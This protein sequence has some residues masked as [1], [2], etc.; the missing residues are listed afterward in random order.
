MSDVIREAMKEQRK[1]EARRKLMKLRTLLSTGAGETFGISTVKILAPIGNGPYTMW[2]RGCLPYPVGT[3][4]NF[5]LRVWEK[6]KQVTVTDDRGQCPFPELLS[7]IWDLISPSWH[8]MKVAARG[9]GVNPTTGYQIS[10]PIEINRNLKD[11]E[12]LYARSIG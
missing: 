1:A 3:L 6:N 11:L 12:E 8:E 9:A 4:Q 5:C 10:V 2:V 7:T